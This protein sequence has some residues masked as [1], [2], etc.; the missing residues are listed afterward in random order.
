MLVKT[1]LKP[2]VFRNVAHALR[3]NG[4][5]VLD[6]NLAHKYETSWNGTFAI[7]ERDIVCAARAYADLAK[8]VADFKACIFEKH[9]VAWKRNDVILWQTWHPVSTVKAAL[10]RV[11]FHSINV[12]NKDGEPIS[13][14]NIDKACFRCQTKG[15]E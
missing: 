10:K 14:A 12:L 15:D 4:W 5:F 13:G 7:V 3:P 9:G 11:G 6:L 8:H 1:R 2:T